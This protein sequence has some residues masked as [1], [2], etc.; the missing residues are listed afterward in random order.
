MKLECQIST[1]QKYFE[2]NSTG[3]PRKNVPLEE[4]RT[5]A[6]ETFFWDTWYF[7]FS[8]YSSVKNV[9]FSQFNKKMADPDI[10]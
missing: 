7:S 1:L 10:C 4:G 9:H 8:S 5:C 3:C 6:K 2:I